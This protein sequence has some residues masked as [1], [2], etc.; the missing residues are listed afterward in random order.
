MNTSGVRETPVLIGGVLVDEYGVDLLATPLPTNPANPI[1]IKARAYLRQRFLKGPVPW[2]WLCAASRSGTGR[3]PLAVAL[4][5]R[6]LAGRASSDTVKLG[7]KAL[8]QMGLSR[9]AAYRGLAA[10]EAVGLVTVER[11]RGRSPRVTIQELD[12]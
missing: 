6:Y 11:A 2:P 1:G 3:S 10:L 4:C 5:I 8:E 12:A 7:H 9:Q